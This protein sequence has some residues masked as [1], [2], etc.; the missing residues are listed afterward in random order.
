MNSASCAVFLDFLKH[1][2]Y[3]AHFTQLC[4]FFG[5][6]ATSD[7]V[8]SVFRGVT[9]YAAWHGSWQSVGDL[10]VHQKENR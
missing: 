4:R 3:R 5:G 1:Y 7:Q 2:Q 8:S 6:K 10:G 9:L